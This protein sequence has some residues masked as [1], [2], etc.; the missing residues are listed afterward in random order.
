[1]DTLPE[2]LSM[3]EHFDAMTDRCRTNLAALTA[4]DT[5]LHVDLDSFAGY[6]VFP[7]LRLQFASSDEF[8]AWTNDAGRQHGLKLNPAYMFGGTPQIWNALYPE[9]ARVRVNV[10]YPP[11]DLL[12]ALRRLEA[13]VQSRQFLK[14][15]QTSGS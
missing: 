6:S 8:L 14:S 12:F 11:A 15:S 5:A 3:N 10:S 4:T 2:F 7:R 1:M 13:A 9:E